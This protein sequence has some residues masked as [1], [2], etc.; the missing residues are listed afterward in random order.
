[1]ARTVLV[2]AGPWVAV[3]P[4]GYGG[5]E[6]VL[7]TLIPELRA[8]GVRVWLCAVGGSTVEVDR[9][10]PTFEHGMLEHITGPYNQMMGIAHAHMRRVVDVLE[11]ARGEID[12]VHD[13]LEVVGA[14]MLAAM[15]RQAPP[16]LQ[17]LHWDLRKHPDF[18]GAFDGRRRAFFNTVSLPQMKTA[19]ANLRR[20]IVAAIPLAT[21]V[22]ATPFQ[23]VKG[24]TFLVLAR[25]AAFKGQDVAARICR[26]R[27]WRCDLAG[28]VA[29]RP[30]AQAL[31]RALSDPSA[32]ARSAPDVQYFL[33]RVRPQLDGCAVRWIGTITGAAKFERLGT[34][35]AL[36]CP[37]SWDEPGAT[38]VV[39]ALACG[40]PVIGMRRGA[41]P[42]LIE[43]GVTGFLARDETE[44]AHYMDRAHELDPAACRRAAEERFT[45]GRMAEAYL[46]AYD[47]VIRRS[48]RARPGA[49]AGVRAA[50]H[51]SHAT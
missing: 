27:G 20:Q 34:A 42:S 36:L 1:M 13:N 5:I 35:R 33:E 8:R 37:I 30:D 7:A 18:Y 39:E 44:F 11:V 51:G 50:A 12:L 31:E 38:N 19:P 6:Q 46:A 22:E 29:G 47:D 4:P 45:A 9:L 17:T 16:V 43:H 23:P 32:G 25:F 2:N 41:L 3:P 10:I 21:R 15:G 26:E 48:A 14:A 24:D 28:P 40:T 49:H